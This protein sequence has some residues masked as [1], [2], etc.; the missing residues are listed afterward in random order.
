MK[1]LFCGQ[2]EFELYKGKRRLTSKAKNW[3]TEGFN[4]GL[5][6]EYLYDKPDTKIYQHKKNPNLFAFVRVVEDMPLVFYFMEHASVTKKQIDDLALWRSGSEGAMQLE[7]DI[8]VYGALGW[9]AISRVLNMISKTPIKECNFRELDEL[10]GRYIC[11]IKSTIVGPEAAAYPICDNTIH[12][13]DYFAKK[14][15]KRK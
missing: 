12:H 11:K 2:E 10:S 14:K 8:I 13:C 1:E 7:T 6:K 4:T 15:C 9:T 5:D 3:T